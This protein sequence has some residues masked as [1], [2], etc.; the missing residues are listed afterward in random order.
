M[1]G[2]EVS[3]LMENAQFYRPLHKGI[4]NRYPFSDALKDFLEEFNFGSRAFI[5]RLWQQL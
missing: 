3:Q 2:V 4:V 1:D 5:L